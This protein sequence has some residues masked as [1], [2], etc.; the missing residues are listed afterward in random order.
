MIQLI[1]CETKLT[2][3]RV[4]HELPVTFEA[5]LHHTDAR[6]LGPPQRKIHFYSNDG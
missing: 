1:E 3:Q 5:M 6:Q 4:M 2:W